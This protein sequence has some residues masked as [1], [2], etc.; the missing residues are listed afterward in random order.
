[1]EQFINNELLDNGDYEN[2]Y[3]VVFENESG[4]GMTVV[5]F[6]AQKYLDA[7]THD[8]PW[9]KILREELPDQHFIEAWQFNKTHDAI[10]VNPV[11]LQEMQVAEAERERSRRVWS[12]QD[13]L[14]AL[15][16]DLM[17]GIIDDENTAHLI[18]LKKYVI[19]LKKLAVSTAPDISWPELSD[20]A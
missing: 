18:K 11:W 19:A 7:F 3:V 20:V 12:V 1:M 15:Q 2:I 17:L 9:L 8:G 4:R 16:T 13:E 10:V 5:N 14:T 6:A